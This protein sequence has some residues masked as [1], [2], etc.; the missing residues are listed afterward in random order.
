MRRLGHTLILF[1]MGCTHSVVD[2]PKEKALKSGEIGNV[3]VAKNGN[4]ANS[5]SLDFPYQTITKGTLSVSP[6]GIVYIR[7]GIYNEKIELATPQDTDVVAIENYNGEEVYIDTVVVTTPIDT[8][9][10]PPKDTVIIEPPF[11]KPP[12]PNKGKKPIK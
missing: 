1:L 8:I 10:T 11:V 4:D 12:R 9:V 2:M 6:N 3:Y 5:G 7:Q